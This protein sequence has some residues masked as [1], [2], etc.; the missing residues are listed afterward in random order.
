MKK[1]FTQKELN[2]IL[3]LSLT[4]THIHTHPTPPT[5]YLCMALFDTCPSRKRRCPMSVLLPA[6]TC[7]ATHNRGTQNTRLPP[8]A[9][10]APGSPSLP[11]F[12]PSLSSSPL[13]P[14]FSLPLPYLSGTHQHPTLHPPPSTLHNP[15]I[16]TRLICCLMEPSFFF[17]S[18]TTST[19]AHQ[20]QTDNTHFSQHQPGHISTKR[21]THTSVIHQ[22]IHTSMSSHTH[23]VVYIV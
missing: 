19:W 6:S 4:C 12:P 15:P 20:H 8:L 3:S 9:H 10:L 23:G 18:A 13:N 1:T 7:P 22:Q 21:T 11:P 14:F 17:S 2:R 16:I 5:A